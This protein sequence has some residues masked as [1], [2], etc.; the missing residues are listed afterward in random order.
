MAGDGLDLIV[1][2]GDYIYEGAPSSRGV[3]KHCGDRELTTL[4]D[5]RNRLAQYR[6]DEDLRAAHASCPWL[7]TWDDHEFDNNY[8]GDISEQAGI[9]R[10]AFLNR[11][12]G[13]Y[14]AY[15]EHMPL[16]KAALPKGPNMQLYRRV[17]FG[18]LAEFA[19]LDTRQYRT[20]Q[21]CGDGVK[22]PCDATFDPAATLLGPEQEK[23]L[24]EGLA[25]SPATWN[26][27]AQQVMMAR[28]DRDYG[29]GEAFPM[30]Q[31]SG[32]DVA[33]NRLL[34]FLHD[35]KI[36]N[37]IVLT[38]DIHTNW[39]NDLLVD[40]SKPDSPVAATEFVG[41]SI[42]SGGNGRQKLSYTDA[43]LAE[44]PF[45]K[46]HNAERGYIR[47]TVTPKEWRSDYNVFEDVTRRHTKQ[48]TR[49]SFV[50]ESGHAGAKPA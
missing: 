10:D 29:D 38:G 26:V 4:D 20:D 32:Y 33:R 45:V 23:W 12:A 5:Y 3:R 42:T 46:F 34:A 30:D 25:R 35:R 16:R 48:T 19:V 31:W 17:P 14:K 28:A 24:M 47:C 41:T 15:Y 36:S 18:R 22:P 21:P 44:N 37:P 43:L 6:S 13:A 27:L 50:V 11:R 39:Q 8:A 1:H 7:V 9:D 49:A 2:L 40:F